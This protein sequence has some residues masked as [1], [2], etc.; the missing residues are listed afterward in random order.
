VAANTAQLTWLW[1]RGRHAYA[2]LTGIAAPE[3]L[4]L[5]GAPTS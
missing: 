2:S 5:P 4:P 3:S 1:L